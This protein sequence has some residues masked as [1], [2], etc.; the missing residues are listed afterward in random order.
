VIVVCLVRLWREGEG[1]GG[2]LLPAVIGGYYYN[3]IIDINRYIY[4]LE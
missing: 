3:R 4:S 2:R 1:G